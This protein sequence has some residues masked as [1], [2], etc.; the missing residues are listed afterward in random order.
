VRKGSRREPKQKS[1][2]ESWGSRL[3]H[4]E[5][6]Q[7]RKARKILEIPSK[8]RRLAEQCHW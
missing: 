1:K 7:V 6:E 8:V 3:G 5:T 2:G 4:F